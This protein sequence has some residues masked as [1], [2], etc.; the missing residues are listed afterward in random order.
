[1]KNKNVITLTK[2]EFELPDGLRK[3]LIALFLLVISAPTVSAQKSVVLDA[4][5]KHGIDAGMLNTGNL[6]PPEDYAFDFRQTTTAAG[7]QTTTVARFDPSSAGEE[8][9]TVVSVDG[10][11]PSKS[12]IKTF[13]KNQSKPS[14]SEQ[15]DESSYKIEKESSDYLVI[16][17][18]QDPNTVSKDAAFMK[19]CRL[20]MTINLRTKKLEQVQAIN[21]RPIKIKILNAEKFD[22]TIKYTRNEQAKCYF[23][24]SQDLNIQ[25]KFIGQAVNVQTTSEYS[26]Y[27][28]K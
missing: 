20:Y 28:K 10:K 6:Q 22:L 25:A 13:R 14:G 24:I 26:N 18:K 1:M 11:S 8:Q 23:P 19:D 17:Y 15:A 27:T 2:M 16:S 21:E 4:F 12:D 5:S 7:K 3:T 9:W